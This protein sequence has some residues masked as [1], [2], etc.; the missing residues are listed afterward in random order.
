MKIKYYKTYMYSWHIIL[1]FLYKNIQVEKARKRNKV[2]H[3]CAKKFY[4]SETFFSSLYTVKS[5]TLV[6]KILQIYI[7]ITHKMVV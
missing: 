2:I 3:I 6:L 7:Y 4:E 1:I 5:T